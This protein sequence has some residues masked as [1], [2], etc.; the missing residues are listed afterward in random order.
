MWEEVKH[1]KSGYLNSE[2][3]QAD[4]KILSIDAKMFQE[5]ADDSTTPLSEFEKILMER[6]KLKEQ[7]N[8]LENQKISLYVKTRKL[9]QR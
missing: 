9:F 7:E 3:I 4:L 8:R 6:L 2:G 5:E 1:Q